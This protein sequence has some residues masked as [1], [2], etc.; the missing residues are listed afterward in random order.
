[1]NQLETKPLET[2]HVAT[3]HLETQ[4]APRVHALAGALL[5]GAL[6]T[7]VLSGC[8]ASDP[9]SDAVLDSAPG[10]ASDPAV[11]ARPEPSA[12]VAERGRAG[13]PPGDSAARESGEPAGALVSEPRQRELSLEQVPLEMRSCFGCHAAV[14]RS[15]LQEH[16]MA[17]SIAPAGEVDAGVVDNP[18]NGRRYVMSR[19]ADGAWLSTVEAD[20]GERKQRVVGRIGA[21]I[22]ANSWITAESDV[23]TRAPS[24]RLFFAPV[25]TVGEHGLVLAPFEHSEPAAGA[26]MELT[27]A[28]LT[29]HLTAPL[30][31]LPGAATGGSGVVFPAN[32]LG[33]DAFERLPSIG[34]D[35]CHGDATYHLEVMASP[36]P[37]IGTGLLRLGSLPPATQRDVCAR[38]HLQGDS[39]W[40]LVDGAPGT[41]APLPAQVPVLVPVEAITDFRFVGQHERLA[42]SSCFTG[43]AAMTCTTCHD[44]HRGAAAQ[45]VESFE[46]ACV[47]CHQ[48]SCNRSAEL[49]VPEVTDEPSRGP[50]GCV[51]CHVRRSQPFDLT[52]V[53]SADH[54]IRR[55]IEPAVAGAPHRQFAAPSGPVELFERERLARQLATPGG[56]TWENAVTALGLA[57][58]G[59]FEEARARFDDLPAPGTPAATR[60]VAP[61]PLQSAL[62]RPAL[63][64]TRALVLLAAGRLDEAKAAFGDALHLDSLDPGARLGRARLRL[65]TGDINGMLEDTQAVIDAFPRAEQPWRLRLE[66]AER[67]GRMDLAQQALEEITRRWPSDPAAWQ[68]LGLLLEQVGAQ[69]RAQEALQRATLLSPSLDLRTKPALER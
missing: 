63:H 39:R 22:F 26:D 15:F 57:G 61:P 59:R 32:A 30:A 44:P 47:A 58:M 34:C 65:D 12:A 5:G 7:M 31:E 2:K 11:A 50:E 60:P 46:A 69:A 56:A 17:G 52:E 19:E 21:G 36:D 8:G 16:G 55:R 49:T 20:G 3:K 29:C 67:A 18:R 64:Q 1:L 28:C 42:L 9:S 45:G 53:R 35:A 38:C 66:L 13:S 27:E 40:S 54:W 68:K 37:A 25:E 6:A 23:I 43:A 4:C 48:A 33:E 10:V 62:D 41:G 24:G 51:D 14:V